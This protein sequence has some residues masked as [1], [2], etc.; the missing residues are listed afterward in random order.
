M[1]RRDFLRVSAG[2]LTGAAGAALAGCSSPA[3]SGHGEP[4][5]TR[6]G[7]QP[8]TT[9]TATTTTLL[10]VPKDY[11]ALARAM[12]GE[13]VLP[14]SPGYATDAQSY[15]PVF[16]GTHPSAI[17]YVE[18][19]RD[20][21]EVIGYGR[22]HHLPLSIRAG[23][24]CYGG[25]STGPGVVVDVSRLSAVKVS[26]GTVSAG[27][28]TRLIDFYSGLAPNGV[29]VPGGSCPTVGLAG[30]ALGGGLG[31]LDRKLGLTCD[32]M[33]GAEV[34]LASGEIV[35]C[36]ETSHSDLFWALRGAGGGNFGV[37]TS[38]QFRTHP[39]GDLG[40]FT[41]VWPWSAAGSVVDA[42]Q[43]WA[44]PGPDELWSNC[45]LLNS[46]PT[47]SGTGP[48]ARVTGVYVGN[49]SVLE[50][51]VADLVSAVGSQ[52]FVRFVGTA[53]LLHTMLIE[54]GCDGDTVA[55][56]HLPSSNPDGTLSRAPF[57][58]KSDIVTAFLPAA[59]VE[60]LLGA[61]EQ[62]E[63]SPV[64]SGGGLALDAAGGAINRVAPQ[65]TAYVH[66]DALFTLQYS[67]N[68]NSGDS[69]SVVMAN[70]AWLQS[71]WQSMR[72]YVSGE[73]Y[74]N[75]ADPQL[76]GWANAYY[77]ANLSRLQQVK[78]LYDPDDVWHFP[79]SVPLP[80]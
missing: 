45:L 13:L 18:S 65:A 27:S 53:G 28:G 52:P 30:L 76:R 36:S 79:Q 72:P 61:V 78:A 40:I 22:D 47:P 46:Q 58:A 7:R 32:N 59:G 21:A 2:V 62:R 44:P 54:A 37:V 68:W 15:N 17:A 43:R 66:R 71:A 10:P 48:A 39:I 24:H 11:A 69:S 35:A 56:C 38:M 42:W 9:T 26:S 14:S 67:A 34:V 60:R 77:G 5:T 3:G 51:L 25:W 57:A 63:M 50:G 6:P 1:R 55:E 33:S 23:G 8:T 19:S 75:Y 74:Q 20:V 70:R 49:E 29:V 41:L 73:A 64:L 16:D 12:R 4:P 31:V 80:S